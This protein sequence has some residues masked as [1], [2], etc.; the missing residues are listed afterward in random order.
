MERQEFALRCKKLLETLRAQ[1]IDK[2]EN[3]MIWGCVLIDILKQILLQTEK[4]KELCVLMCKDLQNYDKE[5]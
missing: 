3:A 1:N 5:L 2:E 4:H